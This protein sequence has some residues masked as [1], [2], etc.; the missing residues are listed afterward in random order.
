MQRLLV[1]RLEEA[2][3]RF[4]K[5]KNKEIH[6]AHYESYYRCDDFRSLLLKSTVTFVNLLEYSRRPEVAP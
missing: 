3:L 5:D 6:F 4:Y 2:L 1:F